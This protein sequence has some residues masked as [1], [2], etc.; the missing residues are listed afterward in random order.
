MA[1]GTAGG[2]GG[3]KREYTPEQAAIVKRIQSC[4]VTEYY[5]ILSVKKDCSEVEIKKAY[6]KVC[7]SC[8][9]S[10]TLK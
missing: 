5:E 1:N 7:L 6:R 8:M 2:S 3:E 10:D 4:K 9:I